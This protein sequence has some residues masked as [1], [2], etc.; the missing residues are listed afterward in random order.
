[1]PVP[2]G[3]SALTF[4]YN[5]LTAEDIKTIQRWYYAVNGVKLS[6]TGAIRWAVKE[7]A[8]KIQQQEMR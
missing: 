8:T 3:F 7:I 6:K 1:M 2:E 5:A 4:G